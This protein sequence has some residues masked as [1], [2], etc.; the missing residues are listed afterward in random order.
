MA[1]GNDRT[2]VA[3]CLRVS[4]IYPRNSLEPTMRMRTE[5][6]AVVAWLIDL[7]PMV[8]EEQ[9]WIDLFE[10]RTRDRAPSDQVR[11]V[12]AVCGMDGSDGARCHGLPFGDGI[13]KPRQR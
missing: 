3:S 10:A 13:K 2:L 8:I 6:Q 5:R 7:W 11:D 1:D 4:V 9:E 12:I